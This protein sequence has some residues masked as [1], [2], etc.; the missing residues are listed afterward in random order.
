MYLVIY[1]HVNNS[2]YEKD[3]VWKAS[4]EEAEAFKPHRPDYQVYQVIF[5]PEGKKY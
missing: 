1:G 4:K 5:V 2:P 3:F